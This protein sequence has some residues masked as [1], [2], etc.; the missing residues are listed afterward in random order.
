MGIPNLRNPLPVLRRFDIFVYKNKNGLIDRSQV[1]CTVDDATVNFYRQGATLSSDTDI[2]R[3]GS[4]EIPVYHTGALQDSGSAVLVIGSGFASVY[5]E[6]VDAM[7]NTITVNNL[8]GL[9]I[10]APRGTRLIPTSVPGLVF[11]DPMGRGTPVSQ[12]TPD[13]GG[14]GRVTGYV[15]DYLFDYIVT[16]PDDVDPLRLFVDGVGSFVMRG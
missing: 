4:A 15:R 13:L 14:S 8:N 3:L 1:P 12:L 11:P 9:M 7:T 2:P 16:V 6:T 5:V 10:S